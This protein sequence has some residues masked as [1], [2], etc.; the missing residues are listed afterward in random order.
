MQ[1]SPLLLGTARN[2]IREEQSMELQKRA[3]LFFWSKTGAQEE[4]LNQRKLFED[5]LSKSNAKR[6][7]DICENINGKI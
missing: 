2:K 6:E 3:V 4:F 7:V 5:Y 1:S